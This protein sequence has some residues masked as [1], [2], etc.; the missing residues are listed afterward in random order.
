MPGWWLVIRRIVIFALGVTVILD[1]LLEKQ[2]ASVGKLVVGLIM[3]GVLPLEDLIRLV[4]R[5]HAR[6]VERATNGNGNGG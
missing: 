5:S 4:Y 1:S 6:R 2:T 3:I